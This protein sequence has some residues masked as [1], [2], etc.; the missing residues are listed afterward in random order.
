M[1]SMGAKEIYWCRWIT[2]RKKL[3]DIKDRLGNTNESGEIFLEFFESK[4]GIVSALNSK[5]CS[6]G[7]IIWDYWRTSC[8]QLNL[9]NSEF[10]HSK[11]TIIDLITKK[12]H[13][14]RA[15]PTQYILCSKLIIWSEAFY[16]KLLVSLYY[17]HYDHA[18]I[19]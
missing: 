6:L 8:G 13:W 10:M 11:E 14:A 15:G 1:K 9:Y 19:M 12:I 7:L 5:K 2:T 16:K 18:K 17:Y 4:S 3:V